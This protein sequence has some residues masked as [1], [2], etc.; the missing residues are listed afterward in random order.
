M[1]DAITH[2][3]ES[4][5]HINVNDFIGDSLPQKCERFYWGFASSKCERM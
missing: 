1:N 2:L 5:F 4:H 3:L